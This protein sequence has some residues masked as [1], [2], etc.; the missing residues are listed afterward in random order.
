VSDHG[1][2]ALPISPCRSRRFD[3]GPHGQRD[4][5]ID[6]DAAYKESLLMTILDII[7]RLTF[8][9]A[10]TMPHMP[11]EYTVRGEPGSDEADYVA[12]WQAIDTDGVRGSYGGRYGRYLY[13]GDGRKYW[14]MGPLRRSRVLNRMVIADDLDRI[15]AEGR[16]TAEVELLV[17]LGHL[18][19]QQAD[20]I[21]ARH[22][23]RRRR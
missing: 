20:T 21:R 13:P 16:F 12:L 5:R 19:E 8:R 3:P 6:R 4:R 17:Q 18:A 23:G 7:A 11:H 2:A 1:S 9:V 14:H 22:R 10:K 15:I